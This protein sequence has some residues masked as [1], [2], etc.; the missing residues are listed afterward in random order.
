MKGVTGLF[1]LP[2]GTNNK[3]KY[4][5]PFRHKVHVWNPSYKRSLKDIVIEYGLTKP[6]AYRDLEKPI[7]DSNGGIRHLVT[8]ETLR[9][10][11]LLTRQPKRDGN[12]FVP[13]PNSQA[14]SIDD[15]Q[16]F[17]HP[18]YGFHCFHGGCHHMTTKVFVNW[19]KQYF[20]E[21]WIK[22]GGRV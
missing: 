13:C 15:G 3:P 17:Y 11:G 6:Q 21:A 18:N 19:L 5:E 20:T 9:L 4:P 8:I 14:H 12:Y 1:R 16:T 7:V 10:A 22:A 2:N